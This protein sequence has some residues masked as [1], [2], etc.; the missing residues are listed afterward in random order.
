MNTYLNRFFSSLGEF[1]DVCIEVI[2]Q[3]FKKYYSI[4]NIVEIKAMLKEYV[5]A[6]QTISTK[7]SLH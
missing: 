2:N 1:L 7:Q 4:E 5:M 6:N 3:G